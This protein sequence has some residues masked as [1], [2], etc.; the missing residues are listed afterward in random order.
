MEG[1]S[2]AKQK[3]IVKAA[4]VSCHNW[5]AMVRAADEPWVDVLLARV[6]P[7]GAHMDNNPETVAEL[8]GK[9]RAKGKGIIG[10]KIFGNGDRT[11]TPDREQ[12]IRYALRKGNVHCMTLGLESP[13]QID[14][15]VERVMRIAG[16]A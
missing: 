6:N 5:E 15:A 1:L 2:R 14:D 8:L 16:E 13:G 11:G 7:F 10:M 9:A 4:G 3:G 12:S